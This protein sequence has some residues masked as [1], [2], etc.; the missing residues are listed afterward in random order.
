MTDR[1]AFEPLSKSLIAV[2]FRQASACKTQKTESEMGW[3]ILR[4]F[5]VPMWAMSGD[6]ARSRRSSGVPTPTR[7]TPKNIDLHDSTPGLEFAVLQFPIRVVRGHPVVRFLVSDH[8]IFLPSPSLP[9]PK[10]A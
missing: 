1:R 7:S 8:P 2:P 9:H 5:G 10:L 3:Q 6:Y 4:P